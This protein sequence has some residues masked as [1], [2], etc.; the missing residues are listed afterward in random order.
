[1][2][3]LT[4]PKKVVRAIVVV[5]RSTQLVSSP[6]LNHFQSA[7]QQSL[8]TETLQNL[9]SEKNIRTHHR[10]HEVQSIQPGRSHPHNA[11]MQI[12]KHT[13][14]LKAPIH[15]KTLIQNPKHTFSLENCKLQIEQNMYPEY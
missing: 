7:S 1:M 2:E 8:L 10:I 14:S 11:L 3:F 6:D 9:D 4:V 15:T 13:F 12:P 5:L